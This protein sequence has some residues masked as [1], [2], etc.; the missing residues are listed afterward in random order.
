MEAA[1]FRGTANVTEQ[2]NMTFPF[3]SCCQKCNCQQ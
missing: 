2:G 3:Y 1:D